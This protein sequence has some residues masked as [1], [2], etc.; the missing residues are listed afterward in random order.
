MYCFILQ[1]K[2]TMAT[3][4][5]YICTHFYVVLSIVLSILSILYF[6]LLGMRW[7]RFLCIISVLFL[8]FGLSFA[9]FS[10]ND[11]ITQF[12]TKQATLSSTDKKTYYLQ[13]YHNLT[14]LA[15]KNRS[16]IQQFTLYTSLK[17]YIYDQLNNLWTSWLSN[18]SWTTSVGVSFTLLPSSLAL[19]IPNV[20]LAKVRNVWL[21]LHNTERQTKSLIPFTYS[22]VLEW[23]ASLWAQ[24]LANIGIVTHN[25]KNT[26][27]WYS[28]ESIKSWF[29]N[30]WIVFVA[31]GQ[32]GQSL[33][34]ENLWWNLYSCKKTDCTD[35]FIA[36]I[37][38]SWTFFMSEKGKSYSPHYN[39]IMGNF[40]RIGLWVVLVGNTYYLV[41]HYT[42]SFID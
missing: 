11:F 39:A 6:L 9:A 1:T 19:H 3:T 37:K 12:Q 16:D 33:F 34:T 18:D 27:W 2:P 7:F 26:D 28:Y 8:F 21:A 5:I 13:V 41:A 25:R 40:S 35:D 10:V 30:Q 31:T 24:H 22:T 20:D 14:L 29:I 42:T 36:A 32:N 15:M 17:N 23:T 4:M 38:K